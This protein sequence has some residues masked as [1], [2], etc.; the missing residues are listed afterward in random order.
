VGL[1]TNVASA[2][3]YL[4]GLVTG[5]LFLVLEPYNRDKTVRFHAFQSIFLSLAWFVC[6]IVA[7]VLAFIPFLGWVFSLLLTILLPLAFLALWLVL[8]YKAYNN[9][10]LVL[11]IIGP[12]AEKQ[13]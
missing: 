4:V 12:M 8:M 11:P 2:L 3:C 6:Y 10:K 9:E 1:E 13:A 7:M 5:V